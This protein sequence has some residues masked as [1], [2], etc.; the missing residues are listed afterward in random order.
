[1]EFRSRLRD[2]AEDGLLLGVKYALAVGL[3][4]VGVSYVLGD[5]LVI[6]Q[7]AANGQMA[8][9]FLQ[10]QQQVLQRAAQQPLRTITPR[11]ELASRFQQKKEIAPSF[12]SPLEEEM[13]E[14][15][16]KIKSLEL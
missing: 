14:L 1:M 2:A 6:R 8:F 3:I 16:R 12:L 15:K 9:E 10:K 11:E 5:Y 4:L 7:R 13:A